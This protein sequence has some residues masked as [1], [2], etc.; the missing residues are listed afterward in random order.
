MLLCALLLTFYNLWD[1]YRAAE[2]ADTAEASLRLARQQSL[3]A[4][5]F[6]LPQTEEYQLPFY[7]EF[8]DV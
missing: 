8:P 5:Q 7:E 4:E 6:Q 1:D 2:Q 3:Q